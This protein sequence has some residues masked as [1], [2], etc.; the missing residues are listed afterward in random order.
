[1]TPEEMV[2]QVAPHWRTQVVQRIPDKILA[3]NLARGLLA[4]AT[5]D[6]ANCK[7]GLA[8]LEMYRKEFNQRT[9]TYRD[10]P[11]HGVESNGADAF[12]Q[13]AQA[14]A[15]GMFGHGVFMSTPV[16][17]PHAPFTAGSGYA[18]GQPATQDMGF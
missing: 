14:I 12:L 1:M 18:T 11:R 13:C 16:Q 2:L 9:Q 8:H 10:V 7:K 4:V 17:T 5:F 15:N 6:E 3:I